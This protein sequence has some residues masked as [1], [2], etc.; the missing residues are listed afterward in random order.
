MKGQ[1]MLLAAAGICLMGLGGYFLFA[2]EQK[3][4]QVTVREESKMSKELRYEV[5]TRADE[6]AREVEVGD[7]ITV[8]YTGWLDA[9]GQPGEKFD[10]SV[11]RGKPATFPIGVGK[12]IKGWDVGIP[13]M[14]VGEKRRFY[15]PSDLGYGNRG[16]GAAIPPN[17]D[18]IFDV[19]IIEVM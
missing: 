6:A 16:A 9:S 13:G 8:H 11:D 19:E 10:S 1:H 18:L 5:L 2:A 7:L 15:I 14:Q 17:A 12:L 4:D 3:I